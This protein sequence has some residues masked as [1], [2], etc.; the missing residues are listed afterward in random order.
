M[1]GN[2]RWLGQIRNMNLR[3]KQN[4]IFEYERTKVKQQSIYWK[5]YEICNE[6]EIM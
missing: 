3:E 1:T 2:V 6:L 5:L 4:K